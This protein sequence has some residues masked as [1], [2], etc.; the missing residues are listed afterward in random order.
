MVTGDTVFHLVK[1]KDGIVGRRVWGVFY[2]QVG[3]EGSVYYCPAFFGSVTF[4]L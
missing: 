3:L 1:E 4:V 2:S